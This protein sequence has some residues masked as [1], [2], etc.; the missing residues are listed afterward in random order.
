MTP[1]HVAV[2]RKNHTVLREMI[3]VIQDSDLPEIDPKNREQQVRECCGSTHKGGSS[4]LNKKNKV[5][6]CTQLSKATICT[7]GGLDPTTL[8]C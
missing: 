7:A 8:C 6:R 3:N 5:S 4:L 1:L 2:Q